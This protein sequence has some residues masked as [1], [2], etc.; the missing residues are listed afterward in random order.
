MSDL[1]DVTVVIK[2]VVKV[3]CTS[4]RKYILAQTIF[5]EISNTFS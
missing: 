4:G 3:A 2:S 5:I 1:I